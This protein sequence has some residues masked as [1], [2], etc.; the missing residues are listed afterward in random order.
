METSFILVIVIALALIVMIIA[1]A[2]RNKRKSGDSNALDILSQSRLSFLTIEVDIS[3]LSVTATIS[4]DKAARLSIG[5]IIQ[6][7]DLIESHDSLAIISGRRLYTLSSKK[8]EGTLI[9]I[10]D[11]E[12]LDN[13]VMLNGVL[14]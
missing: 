11:K 10:T 8:G 14:I 6:L 5:D 1:T 12:E 3:W 9:K 7:C 4:K 13:I 2:R